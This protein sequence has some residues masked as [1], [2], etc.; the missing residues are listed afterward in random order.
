VAK[1]PHGRRRRRAALVVGVLAVAG[2]SAGILLL[3]GSGSHRRGPPPPPVTTTLSSTSA[4]TPTPPPATTGPGPPSQRPPAQAVFGVNVNRLFNDRIYPPTAID[5]QLEAVHNTGATAARSD[6]LWEATERN[7]PVGGVHHYD[8]SFDDAIAMALASH[9]LRWLPIIDYSAPWAQSLPSSDH[10]APKSVGD[11]A[12]YAGALAARYGP[13]GSFWAAHPALSAEPVD[14]YEIWNE[15]DNPTFWRPSPNARQYAE[16]YRRSRDAITSVDR[17][18]RVI[19]GGLTNPVAFLPA[20]IAARPELRGHI[21]GVAIHPYGFPVAGVLARI[22]GAR[23]VLRATGLGSTPLYV[24]EFGWTTH[25]AGA[26][27]YLPASERPSAIER[28]LA[29]LG[30]L[31][32]GVAAAILYTWVTPERNPADKEDW[33]GIHPPRGGSS[34][35]TAAF[36]AGLRQASSRAATIALCGGG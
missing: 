21:D 24:T 22:R 13:Q 11:Y 35:D 10:S 17:A 8:W 6:A 27:D 23:R 34:A 25:P 1:L 12:A 28:T 5:A 3:A 29:D 26:L 32:C 7:P 14:T 2:A 18:A 4:A 16:L 36:A 33:F 19:I 20:M 30:H 15:P 9:R 31:D